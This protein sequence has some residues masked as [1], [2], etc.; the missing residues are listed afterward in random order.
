MG[1]LRE[2]ALRRL[3][4]FR[5]KEPAVDNQST[6]RD[7]SRSETVEPANESP[8]RR[9][10]SLVSSKGS[11]C[12]WDPHQED[13]PRSLT[14]TRRL[15]STIDARGEASSVK[16][17]EKVSDSSTPESS[18]ELY[19]DGKKHRNLWKEAYERLPPTRR[20]RLRKLGYEPGSK[21][22]EEGVLYILLN[23]LQKKRVLCEKK[24][25]K[26]KNKFLVRDYAAKCATWVKLIGDLVVPFAPSQAAGPWGLIKVALE[27]P[28]KFADEMTALLGTVERVLQATYRGR[29]YESVY[30]TRNSAIA[31]TLSEDLVSVYQVVLELLSYSIDMLSK[32]TWARV[33]DTMFDESSGLFSDLTA[34]EEELA[35]TAQACS[36]ATDK[37][38]LKHLQDIG[39]HLPRIEAQVADQLKKLDWEEAMRILDWI[40]SVK[41]G[42]HHD[43]VS[44]NRTP[45]TGE[46]LLQHRTFRDWEE[47]SSSAVLWLRGSP[48]VGKTYLTSKVIDHVQH[49]LTRCPNDE[50]FAYFYCNR[51]EDIRTRPLAVAQSYVRQLSSSLSKRSSSYIQSRF[52]S[53]Y[54]ELSM[55]GSDLDF[56]RCRILLTDSLNLYPRTTLVL[57]AFDECDRASRG[58]LIQLFE[59]L[60]SSSRRP[61]KLFIASR[62]DG[63]VQQQVRSHPNIEVLATDNHQDIQTYISQEMVKMNRM[64]SAFGKL[65]E[66]IESTL[67]EKCQGMF[68]WTYLQLKQLGACTTPEAIRECLGAL[69][70]S[71]DETYDGLYEEIENNPPHDRDLALRALK[72]VLAAREPLSRE[73]LLEAVRI[74][75][76]L[77]TTE[78]CTP[79]SEDDLLSLCRYFLV[80]D[81]E[82]DVW[83]VSHLSVAEY[84]ELRRG[85]NTVVTNLMVGKACLL[86]MLS[87]T[88]WNENMCQWAARPWLYEPGKSDFLRP[89]LYY[90]T[91]Y[92]PEHI[93]I[94]EHA[95]ASKDDLSPVT[96]LLER[97]L[98][99]PQD[100][101][102]Q[103][104]T[105]ARWRTFEPAKYSILAVCEYGFHQVLDRWWNMAQLNHTFTNIRGETYMMIA[106]RKGHVPILRILLK[107]GGAVGEQGDKGRSSTPL[108]AAVNGRNFEAANFLLKEG[109]ADVNLEV[110][111]TFPHMSCALEVAVNNR[112][113]DMVQFLTS[114]GCT[115]TN[116]HLRYSTCGSL[117]AVATLKG[118]FQGIKSLVE[119][120]G[121]D[122]DLVLQYGKYGSALECALT[123]LYDCQEIVEYLVHTRKADVNLAVQTGE[124]GSALAAAVERGEVQYVLFLIDIGKADVNMPLPNFPYGSALARAA[125]L[126]GEAFRKPLYHGRI[127]GLTEIVRILLEEGALVVLDIGKGE[128]VD[129]IEACNGRPRLSPRWMLTNDENPNENNGG[130]DDTTSDA[131][132]ANDEIDAN[133]ADDEEGTLDAPGVLDDDDADNER[134]R[135]AKLLVKAMLADLHKEMWQQYK[136]GALGIEEA[137]YVDAKYGQTKP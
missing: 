66:E 97:F 29:E 23:D 74:N 7:G 112:H 5:H 83:R 60:L 81:S 130:K 47:S 99:D 105:W 10:A 117:L 2:K 103:Y 13:E 65:Q 15:L 79:I 32:S 24:A 72:W 68:Q 125:F 54:E 92:W 101:S 108:I 95:G 116:T 28:V 132:N 85:W 127:S 19:D 88:C 9:S 75:P 44:G 120:G 131:D 30:A 8:R 93:A 18:K 119:Q 102:A 110:D 124:Y 126:A 20:D 69:P 89:L 52:K 12:N 14:G 91:C 134:V 33:L 73:D 45:G 35:K 86:F 58:N 26:Y 21:T 80:I 22:S 38:I 6:A 36:A 39:G 55:R 53:T 25:W 84:F 106:A 16:S 61:V 98:G 41:Y 46:W 63:D 111:N 70:E 42:S 1:G 129:A 136:S 115:N 3:H 77:M 133:T 135:K 123:H 90:V 27:I 113:S 64:N 49:T 59:D 56:E 62:P 37:K 82:R 76:D 114:E 137:K 96:E 40:S 100:S 109:N 67:L 34:K 128:I 57:D 121:A 107:K 78:L 4:R 87:D 104:Q 71:L 122:V 94:L 118:W 51:T 48:G 11:I 31:D 50:G 17:E 43:T